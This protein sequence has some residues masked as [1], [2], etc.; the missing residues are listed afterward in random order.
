MIYNRIYSEKSKSYNKN[1]LN[2]YYPHLICTIGSI[3]KNEE[4]TIKSRNTQIF[5]TF[6]VCFT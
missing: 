1:I 4:C 5:Y 3:I 2:G 6:V